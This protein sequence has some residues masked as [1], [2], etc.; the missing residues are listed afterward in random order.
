M[1]AQHQTISIAAPRLDLHKSRLVM[2]LMPLALIAT[3]YAARKTG[4]IRWPTL[5]HVIHDSLG[6]GALAYAIWLT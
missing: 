5:S 4:S 2:L 6:L 1:I 3:T